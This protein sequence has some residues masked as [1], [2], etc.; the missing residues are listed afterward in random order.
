MA[1]YNLPS[2]PISVTAG[3]DS[4]PASG[5]STSYIVG[6]ILGDNSALVDTEDMV[7]AF[8]P[9]FSAAMLAG[10]SIGLTQAN[11]NPYSPYQTWSGA[12][13]NYAGSST[14]IGGVS[15][16]NAILIEA[17]VF[18]ALL[19]WQMMDQ[20]P[21]AGQLRADELNNLALGTGAV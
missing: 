14:V 18:V 4:T 8:V 16:M 10:T 5:A 13:Q 2:W 20:G 17:R 11:L 12:A 21:D 7:C 3:T 1:S 19:A 6:L 9:G 15:I